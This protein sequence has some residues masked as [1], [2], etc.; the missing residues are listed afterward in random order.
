MEP[1]KPFAGIENENGFNGDDIPAT[2]YMATCWTKKE[3]IDQTIP[4]GIP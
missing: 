1:S 3:S 2:E 4:Q